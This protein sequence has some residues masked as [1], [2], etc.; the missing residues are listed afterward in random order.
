MPLLCLIK[1]NKDEI[2]NALKRKIEDG[3]RFDQ[4]IDKP[5]NQNQNLDKGNT[6]H[7]V[8]M[9]K[10][11]VLLHYKQVSRLAQVLQKPELKDTC[12]NIHGFLYTFIQYE[13]DKSLQNL[14]SPANSWANRVL[15]IDCKSYSIFA[16]SILINLGIK[17]YI[18]QIKQAGFNPDSFS[19]VYIVV[20]VDQ[21]TGSLES[22]CYAI[23]GTLKNNK[24]PRYTTEKSIFMSGLQHLGLNAAKPKRK[25]KRKPAKKRAIKSTTKKTGL[26][27]CSNKLFNCFK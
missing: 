23:D 7:T 22:G 26:S 2:N 15:G 10:K 6:F 5:S 14:R 16:S 21:V 19:H 9:M 11:W 20:P 1:M 18:R 3:S 25:I 24:E 17:H 13:I 12:N 27:G 8:N 4:Y